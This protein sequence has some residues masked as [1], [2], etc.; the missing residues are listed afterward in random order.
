MIMPERF[1]GNRVIDSKL[2]IAM[3]KDV[4]YAVKVIEK[5]KMETL[6]SVQEPRTVI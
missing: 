2:R 5:F 4:E 6:I 3:K 1:F